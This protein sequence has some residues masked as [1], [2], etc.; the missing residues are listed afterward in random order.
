MNKEQH[1]MVSETHERVTETLHPKPKTKWEGLK[2]LINESAALGKSMSIILGIIFFVGTPVYLATQDFLFTRFSPWLEIPERLQKNSKGINNALDGIRRLQT[3]IASLECEQRRLEPV[4]RI[5][6][7]DC[8]NSGIIGECYI[9]YECAAYVT[10]Q[11]TLRGENC[12]RPSISKFAMINHGD[13]EHTVSEYA[14]KTFKAGLK[15]SRVEYTFI[16]PKTVKAGVVHQ[17]FDLSFPC[18]WQEAEINERSDPV[19]F[20]IKEKPVSQ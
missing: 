8:R 2:N 19:V 20:I 17:Y 3:R 9:G 15:P 14:I 10:V 18:P 5:S 4:D 13:R 16:P 11:R 7:F 6:F 1:K 12:D